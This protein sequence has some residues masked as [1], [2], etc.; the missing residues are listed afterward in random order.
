LNHPDP[1]LTYRQLLPSCLGLLLVPLLLVAMGQEV[2][3][4]LGA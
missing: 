4:L 3:L 1:V 2:Y